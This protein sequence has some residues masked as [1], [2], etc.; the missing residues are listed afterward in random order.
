MCKYFLNFS[1]VCE[2]LKVQHWL[3]MTISHV[4]KATAFGGCSF[5]Q[6]VYTLPTTGVCFTQHD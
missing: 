3:V 4:S 6:Y 2:D 5:I 1:E